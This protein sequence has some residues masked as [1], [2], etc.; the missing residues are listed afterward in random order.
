MNKRRHK[1]PGVLTRGGLKRCICI[2]KSSYPK[3]VS[4]QFLNLRRP[5]VHYI[6]FCS[7]R[8]TVA[9]WVNLQFKKHNKIL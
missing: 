7:C 9:F 5:K 6:N 1:M 2:K 4:L 3:E 8:I